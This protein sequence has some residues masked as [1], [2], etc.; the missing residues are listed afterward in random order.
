MQGDRPTAW[1]FGTA[2]KRPYPTSTRV[3]VHCVRIAIL[4]TPQRGQ[5]KSTELWAIVD[6]QSIYLPWWSD[7]VLPGSPSNLSASSPCLISATHSRKVV[8]TCSSANR[9]R[10]KSWEPRVGQSQIPPRASSRARN[11]TSRSARKRRVCRLS[12]LRRATFY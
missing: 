7:W 1:S 9:R 11:S 2:P 12:A 8:L 3:P 5:A 6:F 4:R 10:G